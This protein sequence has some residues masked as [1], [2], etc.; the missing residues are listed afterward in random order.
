MTDPVATAPEGGALTVDQAVA[1]MA[2]EPE[3]GS[4]TQ[5]PEGDNIQSDDGA[6]TGDEIDIAES[7]GGDQPPEDPDA[8]DGPSDEGEQAGEAEEQSQPPIDP[9]HFWSA[10]DKAAFAEAPRHVQEKIVAYEANRNAAA[11]RAIQEA[12]EETK[13]AQEAAETARK[14]LEERQ[15]EKQRID[16][17]LERADQVFASKWPDTIDW[18]ATL[19]N[20]VAQ[21]GQDE[22]FRQYTLLKAEHEAETQQ[23]QQLRAAKQDAEEKAKREAKERIEAE[24][25]AFTERQFAE[26]K[27]R[28]PELVDPQKGPERLQKLV[29]YLGMGGVTQEQLQDAGAFE[30]SLAYKAMKYDEAQAQ[31]RQAA[32]KQPQTNKPKPQGT[33][34]VKPSA[35]APVVPQQQRRVQE[36]EARFAKSRSVD[37]AAALILSLS[38][39]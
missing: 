3:Q 4:E 16:A 27:Q 35:P 32:A 9:P 8:A 38:K 1:L 39:G 11:A 23:L 28:E 37:D 13:R 31:A 29:T 10:E 34:P 20:L 12:R 21:H 6:E 17:V 14:A 24:R 7:E 18:V 36:R 5:A 25:R 19:N 33:P 2:A 15:A 30:L 22:G 26:L